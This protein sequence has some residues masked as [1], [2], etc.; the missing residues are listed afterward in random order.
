MDFCLISP[1]AFKFLQIVD[2]GCCGRWIPAFEPDPLLTKTQVQVR[3]VIGPLEQCRALE[4]RLANLS[5][6]EVD[7][8]QLNRH[9]LPLGPRNDFESAFGHASFTW[10]PVDCIVIRIA[11]CISKTQDFVPLVIDAGLNIESLQISLVQLE[12]FSYKYNLDPQARDS[13]KDVKLKTTHNRLELYSVTF[14][15]IQPHALHWIPHGDAINPLYALFMED[16]KVFLVLMKLIS[17]NSHSQQSSI[18]SITSRVL[19]AKS[20]YLKFSVR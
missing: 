6:V 17:C 19:S 20:K 16:V 10:T 4:S 15:T 18:I 1:L 3:G 13:Y 14:D 8:L 9:P 2:G 12:D 7:K 11:A 5:P